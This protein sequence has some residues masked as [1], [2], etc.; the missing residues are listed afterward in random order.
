M[1]F[2]ETNKIGRANQLII[3]NALGV[4]VNLLNEDTGSYDNK[5]FN[6]KDLCELFGDDV[7]TVC[8][9]LSK[10]DFCRY[11]GIDRSAIRKAYDGTVKGKSGKLAEI[12]KDNRLLDKDERDKFRDGEISVK[13]TDNKEE[14]KLNKAIEKCLN[15]RSEE[16]DQ[17]NRD[18]DKDIRGKKKPR[19]DQDNNVIQDYIKNYIKKY[20]EQKGQGEFNLNKGTRSYELSDSKSENYLDD[21]W[22]I[23]FFKWVVKTTRNK[24]NINKSILDELDGFEFKKFEKL[25]DEDLDQA[26]ERIHSIYL[27]VWALQRIRKKKR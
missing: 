17:E 24:R 1:N 10:A 25:N 13:I 18:S 27:D 11:I 7:F 23:L 5:E 2:G 3:D 8:K 12:L 16:D 19:R 4:L 26:V 22:L 14:K 15:I 6:R 20:I 9:G 21:D